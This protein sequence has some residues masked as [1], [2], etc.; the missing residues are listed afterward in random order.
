MARNTAE[1]NE[2]PQ[3]RNCTVCAAALLAPGALRCNACGRYQRGW[4][5][6]GEVSTATLA[7]LST[8]FSALAATVAWGSGLMNR[9]SRTAITF[10]SA[11][12]SAVTISATNSGRRTSV[13]RDVVLAF[14]ESAGIARTQLHFVRGETRLLNAVQPGQSIALD[15]QAP[16]GYATKQTWAQVHEVLGKTMVTLEVEVEESN[17][18][19]AVR[20][21]TFA[22]SRIADFVLAQIPRGSQ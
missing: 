22:A 13:V 1:D 10:L 8:I 2:K 18:R 15:Y 21:E 7:L 11:D 14:D 6:L 17:G 19:R 5:S 20:K 12:A 4:R 3:P 16:G 9:H